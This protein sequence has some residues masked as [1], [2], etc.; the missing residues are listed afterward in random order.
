MGMLTSIK[1][2][3]DDERCE[4][5]KAAI[6]RSCPERAGAFQ[7]I[8]GR[9]KLRENWEREGAREF[10]GMRVDSQAWL[11]S[12]SGLAAYFE[13]RARVGQGAAVALPSLAADSVWHAWLRVDP[14][15]LAR[16]CQARYGRPMPHETKEE[17]AAAGHDM[18]P[19]IARCFAACC[20][21][22][23][24]SALSGR[25]P[26]LFELDG[27]LRMPGGWAYRF[28]KK[29][30]RVAHAD[31]SK[32]GGLVLAHREQEH[33]GITATGLL[34]IGAISPYAYNEWQ[35][36]AER[37]PRDGG[38]C[39]GGGGSC[40]I[41]SSGAGGHSGGESGGGDG[42]GGDGGGGGCG[43]GCGG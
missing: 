1:K 13:A 35:M 3:W 34:A 12:C 11:L 7:A 31:I 5:R 32:R 30:M 39:G 21:A 16:F 41:G 37:K 15:G 6:S 22:E 18:E 4:S 17:M 26:S 24:I 36:R 33:A 2:W 38:G 42:G 27:K 29:R 25:L 28:D 10:P 19:A 40:G 8:A 9:R 43:G 14:E 20:E 23:G